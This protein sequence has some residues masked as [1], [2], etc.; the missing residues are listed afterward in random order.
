M[1]QTMWGPC[2]YRSSWTRSRTWIEASDDQARR[3]LQLH[4][5]TNSTSAV[6]LCHLGYEYTGP[7]DASRFSLLPLSRFHCRWEFVV[8]SQNLVSQWLCFWD[9]GVDKINDDDVMA[10]LQDVKASR[11]DARDM[12]ILCFTSTHAC[13]YSWPQLPNTYLFV[14]C[15]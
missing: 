13:K 6:E 10:K 1:I 8:H 14:K 12:R 2:N 9:R 4:E 7:N 3:H 5:V 11:S 15:L